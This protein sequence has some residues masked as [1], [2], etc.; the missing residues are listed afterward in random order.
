MSML[1][2]MK[3]R[4]ILLRKSL[5]MI[6]VIIISFILSSCEDNSF[7]DRNEKDCL[8]WTVSIENSQLSRGTPISSE[9]DDD[10]TS[11]GV[12]GYYSTDDFSQDITS[13][14]LPNMEV[15][16]SDNDTWN[17]SPAQYWPVSGKVSFFGYF[18]Y[19]SGDNN[20]GITISDTQT[21]SPELY[22]S[23][24]FNVSD[25]PDL[26][27]AVP[28]KNI[29][30]E[31]VAF[32]FYH[33]LACIGF[34]VSGTDNEI[35]Y[36]GI[37]GI[38]TS[39]NLSLDFDGNTPAWTKVSA[40]TDSI[41]KLGL[42][43]ETATAEAGTPI[44]SADGYLMIIPQ[45]I[46]E[47]AKLVIKYSNEDPKEISLSDT[48]LTAWEAGTKYIYEM[49]GGD[50]IFDVKIDSSAFSYGGG[51][52]V[53]TIT[54]QF[55]QVGGTST[56]IGWT[57]EITYGDDSPTGWLSGD[58][59]D[60]TGGSDITKTLTSIAAPYTS[61]NTD[62][63]DLKKATAVTDKNLSLNSSGTYTTAN[64]YIVNAPGT[65]KFLCNMLGNVLVNSTS[66]TTPNNDR[67]IGTGF[68]NYNGT[69]ITHYPLD[70]RMVDLTNASAQI[71]WQDA[72]DLITNPTID[73]NYITFTVNASTI[74]QG[75]AVIGILN[76]S[77]T[78]MWSWHIWITNYV[79]G[80][81]DYI[82]SSDQ[83]RGIMKYS[84]GRCSGSTLNYEARNATIKFTQS[85]TGKVETFSL[86]QKDTVIITKESNVYYQWGR[87]DPMLPSSGV[88]KSGSSDIY[89]DKQC[90]GSNIFTTEDA[91]SGVSLS[92]AIKN[93][94]IFYYSNSSSTYYRWNAT[95][96]ND[97]WLQQKSLYD[98]SP[99]GYRATSSEL[100]SDLTY[101]GNVN[102]WKD[103]Y[104]QI[105]NGNS[106]IIDIYAT[107]L[108][109][110]TNGSVYDYGTSAYT[111]TLNN[112]NNQFIIMSV[113]K[114]PGTVDSVALYVGS[115]QNINNTYSAG[116]T[117]DPQYRMKYSS[118][119]LTIRPRAIDDTN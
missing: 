100:F 63:D 85:S 118:F 116:Q 51:D 70:L 10:F 11:F 24:P 117:S 45:N 39:G 102:S 44:M 112:Q 17:L 9:S 73:G 71:I 61:T 47:N 62:D 78:I 79:L 34:S 68:L 67:C 111:W 81:D 86:N 74:V 103:S 105:T 89:E 12:M 82:T 92:E 7:F 5:F 30:K 1:Y 69:S 42:I 4:K 15:L 27:V 20:Y 83:N 75:N 76:S 77:G 28:K 29:F 119:G 72:P 96:N 60:D 93:P 32:T 3:N 37:S 46:S 23:L 53:F 41:F 49:Q 25:Q 40:V 36:V 99:V 114:S 56:D 115:N 59:S 109:S 91:G 57:A 22:Y 33:A 65:Y 48:N 88:L 2:T 87:K 52:I 110:N 54:S 107:G 66:E 58:I 8:T 38:S 14:F 6:F 80:Q 94:N 50:Y 90:Y 43:E 18:P 95:A 113:M 106:E 101:N 16:K 98:P 64:C 13:S 31:T 26:M 104:A 84:L 21:G 108:R 55:S 19:V 35:E 97:L